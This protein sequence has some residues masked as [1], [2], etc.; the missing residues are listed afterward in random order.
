M[1]KFLH[2]DD[3][4]YWIDEMEREKVSKIAR[5]KKGFLTA[6]DKVNGD[7][8]KLSQFWLNKRNS[9]IA[10]TLA[11]YKKNPTYRRFLSLIAWA[12]MPKKKFKIK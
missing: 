11:A 12:Y 1:Y 4:Y 9:F 10:R 6:Y 3:I 2:I 8:T 7:P 5:S